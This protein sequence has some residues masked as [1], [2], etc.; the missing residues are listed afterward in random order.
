MNKIKN[1]VLKTVIII[2]IVSLILGIITYFLSNINIDNTILNYINSFKNNL[3]YISG[4]KRTI[5]HNLNY[6]FLIWLSGL[7]IIGIIFSPI[8]L[9][10][11]GISLGI[12]ITSI[13]VQFKLKGLILAIIM[14]ISN[15]ILYELIFI[16]LSYY[17]INLSI[18]TIKT[19][20]QNTQINIKSYYKNYFIRYLI[21]LLILIITSII[22]IYIVS[23]ILKYIII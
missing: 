22:D 17:S 5:F 19:L 2:Y 12:T 4:L 18:K 9:I 10:L 15:I 8:S 7:L 21:L 16:L 14:L 13:I 3:N 1:K 11:R 6:S 23:T 20:K